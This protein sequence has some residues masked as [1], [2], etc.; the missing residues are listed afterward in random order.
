MSIW[1]GDP[2]FRQVS[3]ELRYKAGHEDGRI[4]CQKVIALIVLGDRVA[5]IPLGLSLCAVVG[6]KMKVSFGPWR[7]GH[8]GNKCHQI[9]LIIWPVKDCLFTTLCQFDLIST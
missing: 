8:V 1:T 2:T 3:V 5:A 9:I 7:G 4:V 6:L